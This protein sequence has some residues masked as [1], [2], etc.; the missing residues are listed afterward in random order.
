MIGSIL[1]VVALAVVA[2]VLSSGGRSARPPERPAARQASEPSVPETAPADRPRSPVSPLEEKAARALAQARALQKA[3]PDDF[4]GALALY[5][6]L[7]WDCRGTSLLPEAQREYQSLQAKAAQQLASELGPLL[8]AARAARAKEELARSRTLIG[9]ARGRHPWPDWIGS[10]DRELRELDL[11]E[12]RLFESLRPDAE[13][14]KARGDAERTKAILERVARWGAPARTQALEKALAAIKAP[15]PLSPEER[16]YRDRWAAALR[17]A[18]ARCPNEAV[19]ELE[20]ARKE[21]SAAALGSDADGD[22]ALLRA[23]SKLLG[24]TQDNLAKSPKGRPLS[25]ELESHEPVEGLFERA[26]PGGLLLRKEAGIVSTATSE[27]SA[28]SLA[29]LASPSDDLGRRA[30]ALWFLLEGNPAAEAPAL[31]GKYLEFAARLDRLFPPDAEEEARAA[32]LGAERDF[33]DPAARA[34]SLSSYQALSD[35]FAATRFVLR[36]RAWI[37]ARSAAAKE[38]GRDYVFLAADLSGAGAFAL[39]G[40]KKGETAWTSQSDSPALQGNFVEFSFVAIAGL[41]YKAW[42]FLGGCCA[43]TF[44]YSLQGTE[45]TA[46]VPE[47]TGER[48]SAQPGDPLLIS[49]KPPAVFL[50]KLHSQHGGPKVPARWEWVPLPLPKYSSGGRKTVR[51]LGAQQGFSVRA[52]VVS[53]AREAPPG[54]ADIKDLERSRPLAATSAAVRDPSLVAHW[55]FDEGRGGSAAD[56]SGNGLT[57]TLRNGPTWTT[58][59]LGGALSFNGINQYVEIGNSPK[60]NVSGS[61]TLSAWVNPASVGGQRR[62]VIADYL[63]RGDQSCYALMIDESGRAAFFW[64]CPSGVE[65]KAL[66]RSTLKAGTWIHLAGVWDGTTRKIFVN[67][68]L[69]GEEKVSQTRPSAVSTV[70]IGRPGGFNGLYGAGEID[71]VRLYARALSDAEL[72]ALVGKT[73]STRVKPPTPETVVVFSLDLEGGKKPEAVMT[74]SVVKAPD[75][76]GDHWCLGAEPQP[77]GISPLFINVGGPGSFRFEGEELLVFDYWVDSE[78]VSISFNINNRTQGVQ[79]FSSVNQPVPGKWTHASIRMADMGEAE[80]RLRP[81]DNVGGLY[82]QALGGSTR[83][84]FVDNLQVVKPRVRK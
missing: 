83:K 78:V 38:A 11:E 25:L 77:S 61:F 74:G 29:S 39:A 72:A 3:K 51:I 69:E 41:D 20:G 27:L 23:W 1:T 81:G 19:G 35:R 22:L 65:P 47:R 54:E 80:P 16:R 79:H 46:P 53:A 45:M 63:A 14:A 71:D 60:L 40:Q 33:S 12:E 26:V 44:N 49:G 28:R 34:E 32:Y 24:A 57:G 37:A 67:G 75:R 68:V 84:F 5:E 30:V 59:R 10:L 36:R 62:Y 52:A 4:S 76:T 43:E 7:I 8:E 48:G 66:S 42:A 31:P 56:A 2:A 73:P 70:S 15:V 82:L 21:V 18:A 55:K 58:G 6:Q 9:D 13:E 50:K 64:E 17:W